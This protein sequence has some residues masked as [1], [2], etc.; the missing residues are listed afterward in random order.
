MTFDEVLEKILSMEARV[1]P[2]MREYITGLPTVSKGEAFSGHPL[3]SELY[4]ADFP[5][6]SAM[7]KTNTLVVLE[8]P[9]RLETFPYSSGLYRIKGARQF[10]NSIFIRVTDY[11]STMI[12][13]AA[14]AVQ[15]YLG[16]MNAFM[17]MLY[18]HN[19]EEVQACI[20][21]CMLSE[22]PL[23]FCEFRYRFGYEENNKIERIFN[24][25]RT[26]VMM[27]VNFLKEA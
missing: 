3:P 26:D 27:I 12:H 1:Y 17:N 10:E 20:V 9:H 14:H 22:S 25:N 16:T 23:S 4:L 2:E 24:L 8:S 15:D 5:C 13:E 7:E 19:R 6:K 18:G 11:I 21:E